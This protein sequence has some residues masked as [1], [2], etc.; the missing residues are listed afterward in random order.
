MPA[1]P[2]QETTMSREISNISIF[3]DETEEYLGSL[4]PNGGRVEKVE[5]ICPQFKP[6]TVKIMEIAWPSYKRINIFIR[7]E[8]ES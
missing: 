5:K 3:D 6:G 7:G 2:L 8:K 1:L 4:G